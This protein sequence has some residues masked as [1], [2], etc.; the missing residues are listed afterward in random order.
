MRRSIIAS[1]LVAAA[2]GLTAACSSSG[3][4]A[5]APAGGQS[6]SQ[7]GA[8][9]QAGTAAPGGGSVLSEDLLSAGGSTPTIF[10]FATY[11]VS[12]A[13]GAGIDAKNGLNITIKTATSTQS[14]AALMSGA[15]HFAASAFGATANA[16][17]A[18]LP[19][20]IVAAWGL[21]GPREIVAAKNITSVSQL[22]GKPFC[23][24]SIGNDSQTG[25]IEYWKKNG[26]DPTGLHWVVSGTPAN[27]LSYASINRC[28]AT[29][30]TADSAEQYVAAHPNLHILVDAQQWVQ[31]IP[32]LGGV[33]VTTDSYIKSDPQVIQSMVTAIIEASRESYGSQATFNGL[34]QKA[35]PSGFFSPALLN[36]LYGI[37][38][39]DMAVNG[40]MTQSVLQASY[41]SWKQYVANP[42]A[43]KT[44]VTGYSQ[45]VDPEF[46]QAALKKLGPVSGTDDT[47]DFTG[48]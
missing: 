3:T 36:R 38:R 35:F 44:Q 5:A 19:L 37:F 20:K 46:V 34:A 1:A 43:E 26:M 28:A 15:Q 17:A 12:G 4:P 2:V 13:S 8:A 30:A 47:G 18:G 21:H 25:V 48:A 23:I 39:P 33:L 14:S 7:A 27:S 6:A 42:S 10:N 11:V 16:V 45:I 40:G 41:N 24:T 29:A 9:S 22:Q 31:S 32:D